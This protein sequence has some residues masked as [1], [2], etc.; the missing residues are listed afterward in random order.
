MAT[1]T[2]QRVFIWVIAVVMLVGSIGM[3]FMIILQNQNEQDQLAEQQRQ[4]AELQQNMNACEAVSTEGKE[5]TKPEPVSFEADTVTELRTEDVVVGTGEEVTSPET[6]VTV[7]YLVNTPDGKSFE[8][9]YDTNDPPAFG[10]D[11]V[12]PGWQEGM[13]GMKVGGIRQLY[14]PAD[15]AYGE[16]GTA[17][18]PPNTPLFFHIELVGIKK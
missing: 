17:D 15:K 7:H 3:Y 8:N 14:V 9:S 5:F 1:K 4:I 10:L 12:I 2:S 18:V 11:Q 13:M 6:C 16:Q